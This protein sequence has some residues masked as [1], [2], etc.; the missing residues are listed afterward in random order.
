MSKP[1]LLIA[2]S[3]LAAA[4]L[5]PVWQE[6][7]N[8]EPYDHNTEYAAGCIV[9]TDNRF[10]E[11]ERYQRIKQHDYRIILSYL[12]DSNVNQTCE[13]INGEFVLRA[14]DWMWIQESLQWRYWNY[15][16]SRE[17]S[18]PSKF[19]LLLM[20]LRRDARDSLLA[21]ATPYLDSSLHSYV[22]KGILLPGDI[23]VQNPFNAGTANDRLYVPDWYAQT[24][25]SLVSETSVKN[26]LFISEK[27]F[28]PLAYN[29]PLIVYGCP[30]TLEYIRS[31]GFETF[32]HRIDESYD[33]V[34]NDS[35]GISTARLAKIAQVLEDLYEE[36]AQ[37][38][39]VFQDAKTQEILQ[40]NQAL[41]FDQD[42]G[43]DLFRQQ[44]VE[45]IMEFI[46][47]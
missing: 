7:F 20:N 35:R 17:P 24:C 26:E 1:K 25:F 16:V 30:G 36:F 32:G 11:V 29:H 34:P 47:S 43:R 37:T 3:N 18:V 14:R 28:K 21:Q 38:G 40:H 13:T 15:H 10:G 8:I 9:I 41:F 44:V 31:L 33:S 23:F 45:P 19:L 46:E 6:F 12:M 5:T 42:R 39:T 4:W 27:I 22:E 2:D